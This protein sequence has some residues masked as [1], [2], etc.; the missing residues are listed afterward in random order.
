MY[1]LT[2]WQP[3][4]SHTYA[5]MVAATQIPMLASIL[6]IL[7]WVK[8]LRA[9]MTCYDWTACLA[10]GTD[11]LQKFS[12]FFVKVALIQMTMS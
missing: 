6:A 8:V 3:P 9:Y 1:L 11:F 5:N 4:S 2:W 7:P 12:C 10:Q